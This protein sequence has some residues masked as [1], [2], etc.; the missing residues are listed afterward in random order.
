MG[1]YTGPVC[2]LCRREGEKLFLKGARCLGAKCAIEDRAYPPGVHGQ[3]RKKKESEY[4]HQLREKQK[5]RRFYGVFER[6]FRGYFADATRQRGVTGESMLQL[7]ETRLDSVI[8]RSGLVSSRAEARQLIT[9]RHFTVDGKTVN[10]PSFQVKP[11][12]VIQVREKSRNIEAFQ[13]SGA[14]RRAPGWLQ[15]DPEGKRIEMISV[16]SRAEM[17]LPDMHEQLIVEY[18]SR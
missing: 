11:G 15:V 2:K 5:I 8:Y 1:R 7:L 18:Y 3:G 4:G 13:R 14:I 16:P 9:H 12:M 17:D 6:Q 10:V